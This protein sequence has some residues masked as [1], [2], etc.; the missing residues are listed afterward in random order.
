MFVAL[1]MVLVSEQQDFRP[2]DLSDCTFALIG[3]TVQLGA[4]RYTQFD[5]ILCFLL[6]HFCLSIVYLFAEALDYLIVSLSHNFSNTVLGSVDIL[7][8]RQ[9]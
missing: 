2:S 4:F 1:F 7:C 3:F 9:G 6:A 5:W 8:L